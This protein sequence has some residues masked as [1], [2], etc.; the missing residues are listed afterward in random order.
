MQEENRK[1]SGKERLITGLL[2]WETMPHVD[3]SRLVTKIIGRPTVVINLQELPH[4]T[5][6]WTRRFYTHEE[7]AH[8]AAWVKQAAE[9]IFPVE[10]K[11][12][13]EWEDTWTRTALNPQPMNIRMGHKPLAQ[14]P[15]TSFAHR[16]PGKFAPT[17]SVILT[18]DR[19]WSGEQLWCHITGLTPDTLENCPKGNGIKHHTFFHELAETLQTAEPHTARTM[20]SDARAWLGEI[21][22]NFFAPET[23]SHC[24]ELI[25]SISPDQS[26][27]VDETLQKVPEARTLSGFHDAQLHD[28]VIFHDDNLI[29][30]FVP[31]G[32]TQL[33][34]R[35][36]GVQ[37][38][39]MTN[40]LVNLELRAR[41]IALLANIQIIQ[42]S[43]D[44]K[45]CGCLWLSEQWTNIRQ[46]KI[47]PNLRALFD[48]A[49]SPQWALLVKPQQ[50]LPALKALLSQQRISCPITEEGANLVAR[51]AGY[52][53]PRSL[54]AQLDMVPF[55]TYGRNMGIVRSSHTNLAPNP[56]S[57]ADQL[58]NA[59]LAAAAHS[60]AKSPAAAQVAQST[61][62][63]LLARRALPASISVG[64]AAIPP[65][66]EA[67]RPE[68][69]KNPHKLPEETA[70]AFIRRTSPGRT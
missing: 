50:K 36:S 53:C 35:M 5:P 33:Y 4:S 45:S 8:R 58:I 20:A 43:E 48:A 6:A 41:S 57:P 60:A 25:S 62:K 13:P 70:W 21:D 47:P 31:S 17:F 19:R 34:S 18:P 40:W 1:F 65:T 54:D 14:V 28:T 42:N 27:L 61:A 44:M 56:V 7:F 63:E 67:A 15:Q 11:V 2:N 49:M 30:S 10:T 9:G 46:D 55:S 3:F 51:A 64:N 69:D 39:A 38:S 52:F 68:A 26:K 37:R 16:L 24:R 22:A 59:L 23:L 66:S 12:I 29:S 32:L